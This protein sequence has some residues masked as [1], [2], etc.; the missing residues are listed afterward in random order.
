MHLFFFI[1]TMIIIMLV[2]SWK[3]T[4]QQSV[5]ERVAAYRFFH[6]VCLMS[7][8]AGGW[9]KEPR[10]QCQGAACKEEI[11][12]AALKVGYTLKAKLNWRDE[13]GRHP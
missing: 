3:Q 2:S 10:S 4:A 1:F 9:L 12:Y 6:L 11:S 8:Q 5:I 7:G 13:F